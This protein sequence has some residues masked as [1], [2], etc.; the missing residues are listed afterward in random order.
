MA[1]QPKVEVDER[2]AN[3]ILW[4]Q[5]YTLKLNEV[6]RKIKEKEQLSEQD[7]EVIMLSYPL[8]KGWNSEC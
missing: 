5:D 6:V 7:E 2:P 1:T 3:F 8:F 4:I